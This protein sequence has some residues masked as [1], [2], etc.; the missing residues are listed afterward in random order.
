MEGFLTRGWKLI[1]SGCGG[2][3]AFA[4]G[5]TLA[6]RWLHEPEP[7]SNHPVGRGFPH[8]TGRY[9]PRGS[10]LIVPGLLKLKKDGRISEPWMGT[11][12]LRV[13]RNL[14]VGPKCNSRRVPALYHMSPSQSALTQWG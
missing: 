14:G 8:P 4:Q 12:P 3:S 11:Y 6:A 2:T 7:F 5:A 1:L 10:A 9:R 13:R